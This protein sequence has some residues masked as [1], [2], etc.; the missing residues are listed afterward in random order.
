[1]ERLIF[2]RGQWEELAQTAGYDANKLSEL[3]NVSIRQLQRHFRVRFQCSPQSWLDKRRL[4]KAQALLLSGE[5]VKKVALELG[6][7]YPSH[8][9][10]H[11]KSRTKMTPSQYLVSQLETMPPHFGSVVKS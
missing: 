10:R 9:C 5:S 3:C 2:V 4:E 6:F 11:F 8:F 7:K 1:M